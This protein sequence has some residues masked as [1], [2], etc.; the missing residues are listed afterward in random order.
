MCDICIYVNRYDMCKY[1]YIVYNINI[2]VFFKKK[3]Q[4]RH[5]IT[6]Q[7]CP[8]RLQ[9][10]RLKAHR[11]GELSKVIPDEKDS[12]EMSNQQPGIVYIY[13]GVYHQVLRHVPK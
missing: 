9:D 12:M 1:K 13:L 2:K 7:H 11:R 6:A 4:T 10:P 3:L 5:F 8:E